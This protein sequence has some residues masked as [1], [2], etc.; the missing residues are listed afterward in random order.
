[1]SIYLFLIYVSHTA[2]ENLEQFVEFPTHLWKSY[3]YSACMFNQ[4]ISIFLIMTHSKKNNLFTKPTHTH[5]RN[6]C[7]TNMIITMLHHFYFSSSICFTSFLFN[8]FLHFIR[9]L[10][11]NHTIN[12]MAHRIKSWQTLFLKGLKSKY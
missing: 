3:L 10:V 12:F 4:Q 2:L 9:M 7:F 6:K 5:T 11:P 8:S 1:M